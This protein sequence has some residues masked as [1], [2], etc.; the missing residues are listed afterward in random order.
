MKRTILI[1][2]FGFS[3]T[4]LYTG[5]LKLLEDRVSIDKFDI[6]YETINLQ[7]ENVM[8]MGDRWQAFGKSMSLFNHNITSEKFDILVEPYSRPYNDR[9][10][11]IRRTDNSQQRN[12]SKQRNA[13]WMKYRFI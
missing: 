3:C 8:R 1:L 12:A 9:I 4:L 10:Y 2:L 11:Y 13:S 7:I 5:Y 6:S